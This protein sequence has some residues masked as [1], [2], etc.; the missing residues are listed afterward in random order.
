[1]AF[2]K[3]AYWAQKGQPRA[4]GRPCQILCC[5]TCKGTRGTVEGRN[6]ICVTDSCRRK[7]LKAL[8]NHTQAARAA[9]VPAAG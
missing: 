2:D 7:M 8:F 1:M 4:K 9:G 5:P 3:A 6:F